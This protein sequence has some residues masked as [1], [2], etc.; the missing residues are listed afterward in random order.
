MND[1][2]WMRVALQEAAAAQAAGDVPVGA[3]LVDADGNVLAQD[4]NRREVL[5]DPTAHAEI[6]VMRAAA[7]RLSGWRLTGTTLFVTLEPCVMCAGA[8]V[9]GRVGRVVFATRDPKGGAAG[10]L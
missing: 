6:L 4:H 5:N 7:S 3:V 9:A 10:S 2:D 1:Y 8:I